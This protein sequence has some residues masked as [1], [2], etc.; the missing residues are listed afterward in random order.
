MMGDGEKLFNLRQRLMRAPAGFG[1]GLWTGGKIGSQRTRRWRGL[2]SNQKE[3]KA[4][5]D[6]LA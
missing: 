2:D 5:L 6:E 3:A 4:L 1:C